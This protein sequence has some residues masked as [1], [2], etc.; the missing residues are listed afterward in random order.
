MAAVIMVFISIIMGFLVSWY[1]I[2]I[3]TDISCFSVFYKQWHYIFLFDGIWYTLLFI[4]GL[5]T[6]YLLIKKGIKALS[7]IEQVGY[8]V[9]FLCILSIVSGIY[10]LP[11]GESL[12]FLFFAPFFSSIPLFFMGIHRL[13]AKSWI[14]G[15]VLASF[16][17][18]MFS[19]PY[20]AIYNNMVY[21]GP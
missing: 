8:M 12:V 11:K 20:F 7:E 1:G 2:N 13:C 10:M 3:S 14:V 9:I 19:W 5:F 17:L 21:F 18:M 15:T 4:C 6:L 16:A